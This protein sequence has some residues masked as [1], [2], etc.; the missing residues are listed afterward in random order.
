MS[1]YFPES[2]TDQTARCPNRLTRQAFE[3]LV[4][5]LDVIEDGLKRGGL[6]E[7]ILI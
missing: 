5:L 4:C 2:A 1:S 6:P 3:V 7:R